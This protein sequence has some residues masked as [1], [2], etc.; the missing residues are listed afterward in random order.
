MVILDFE[1]ILMETSEEVL[2][3]RVKSDFYNI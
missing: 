3:E 2:N 1:Q